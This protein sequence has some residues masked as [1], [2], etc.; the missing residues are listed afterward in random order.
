[1]TAKGSN[2]LLLLFLLTAATGCSTVNQ[3]Q[4]AVLSKA[5]YAT[6]D[7]LT[8]GRVD[9]AKAYN[10]QA[11]RLLPPP[12]KRQPVAPV[13][14]KGQRYVILP[15]EFTGTPPLTVGS[16]ALSSLTAAD[17]PLQRQF[18]AENRAL[19]QAEKA[20]DKVIA[21][22][23]AIVFKAVKTALVARQSFW[24]RFL[25]FGKVLLAVAALVAARIFFPALIPILAALGRLIA[26]AFGALLSF[27]RR[28]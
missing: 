3:R 2:W 28:R 9:L 14:S 5:V 19:A 1:M 25:F 27:F 15:V 8:A 26:G 10:S 12:A 13:E 16:P 6:Q 23:E 21:E 24:G 7:A 18:S 4:N 22:K 17:K 11:S 20:A